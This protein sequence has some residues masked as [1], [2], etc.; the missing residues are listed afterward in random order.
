MVTAM[1][2]VAGASGARSWLAHKQAAWLTP[3]RLRWITVALFTGAVLVAG[4]F[5]G[6]S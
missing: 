4:T 5:S 3:R 6:S 1:G 2:S